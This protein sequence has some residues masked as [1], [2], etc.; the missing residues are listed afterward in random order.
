MNKIEC[1]ICSG[2]GSAYVQCYD[3]TLEYN[4]AIA[5]NDGLVQALYAISCK[6]QH[7]DMYWSAYANSVMMARP[8]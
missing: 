2:R 3:H 7:H 8:Q 6:Q 1:Y 4:M 5:S